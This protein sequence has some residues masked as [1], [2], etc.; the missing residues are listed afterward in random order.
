MGF[1]LTFDKLSDADKL[2][3]KGAIHEVRGSYRP[4]KVHVDQIHEG[5]TSKWNSCLPEMLITPD[6]NQYLGAE[7]FLMT[8]EGFAYYLPILLALGL[9]DSLSDFEFNFVRKYFQDIVEL[10]QKCIYSTNTQN[11]ATR[12]SELF[13]CYSSESEGDEP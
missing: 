7:M 3:V 9:F 8:S 11:L 6:V 1:R 12:W 10:Q 5:E 13:S 2:L 4:T